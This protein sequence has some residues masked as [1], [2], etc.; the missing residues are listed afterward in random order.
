MKT[1]TGNLILSK[2]QNLLNV[3]KKHP[4]WYKC[5]DAS[6][7]HTTIFL[8]FI[9]FNIFGFKDENNTLLMR[10]LQVEVIPLS[11]TEKKLEEVVTL[12]SVAKRSES[13]VV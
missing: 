9:V 11:L 4:R 7:I 13:P 8:V 6:L 3:G 1:V 5:C 2:I 12:V 10:P